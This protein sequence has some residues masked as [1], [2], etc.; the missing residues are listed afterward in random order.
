M[1]LRVGDTVKTKKKHPCGSDAWEITRV[2]MDLKLRCLL[3]GHEI[4]LPRH[5]AEK[6]I[7]EIK[8]D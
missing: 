5:K 6:S 8:E 3:C 7:K 4:M 2:G 1:E